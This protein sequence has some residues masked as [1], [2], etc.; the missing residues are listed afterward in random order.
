[1]H[2]YNHHASLEESIKSTLNKIVKEFGKVGILATNA[3]ITGVARAEDY[4]YHNFKKMIDVNLIGTSLFAHTAGKWWID[5]KIV[6]HVRIYRQQA[7][8]ALCLQHQQSCVRSANEVAC[9]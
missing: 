1:L 5:N 2:A 3:G 6:G 4:P 9:F 7:T 8:E